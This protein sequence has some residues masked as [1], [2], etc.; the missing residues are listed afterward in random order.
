MTITIDMELKLVLY[1]FQVLLSR[2][3]NH[4][5]RH[6][7]LTFSTDDVRTA[8][9]A[10]KSKLQIDDFMISSRMI[11]LAGDSFMSQFTDMLN[12]LVQRVYMPHMWLNTA[13]R[14]IRKNQNVSPSEFKDLRPIAITPAVFKIIDRLIYNE[15]APIVDGLDPSQHRF[16]DGC[17]ARFVSVLNT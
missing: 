8:S 11:H 1:H 7:S 15:L 9:V 13:S 10:I 2:I 4:S 5:S 14:L 3:C 17:S 16:T 12:S 6:N